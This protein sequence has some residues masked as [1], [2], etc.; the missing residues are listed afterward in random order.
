MQINKKKY[1]IV[2]ENVKKVYRQPQFLQLFAEKT[3]FDFNT[4]RHT[5]IRNLLW[6]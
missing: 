3:S 2:K 4:K 6:Q 5:Q 1:C